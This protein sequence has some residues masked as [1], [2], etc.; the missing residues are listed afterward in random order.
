[1]QIP[2]SRGAEE[3]TIVFEPKWVVFG[4]AFSANA[5]LIG[6]VILFWGYHKK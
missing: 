5:I 4:M 3:V 1:M 2:I 6:T